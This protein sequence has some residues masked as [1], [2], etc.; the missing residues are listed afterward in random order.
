MC[1]WCI[2]MWVSPWQCRGSGSG[3][4]YTYLME[5]G[6][7]HNQGRCGGKLRSHHHHCCYRH[8]AAG[9]L[10]VQ[11]PLLPLLASLSSSSL[12]GKNSSSKQQ[13][14]WQWQSQ[15][16]P[17]CRQQRQQ[18]HCRWLALAPHQRQ[19]RTSKHAKDPTKHRHDEAANDDDGISNSNKGEDK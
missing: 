18:Q 8:P 11:L 1:A 16:Q 19:V 6:K 13:Q 12:D 15:L 10:A 14:Q 17:C 4:I 7:R 2:K 9:H 3:V 5:H